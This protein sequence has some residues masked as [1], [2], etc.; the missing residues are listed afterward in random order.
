MRA[1]KGDKELYNRALKAGFRCCS[2]AKPRL[3][4]AKAWA[5]LKIPLK[6]RY[7]LIERSLKYFRRTVKCLTEVLC[8]AAFL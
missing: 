2:G 6:D 3:Y 4:I 5:G 8:M 7:T 1:R